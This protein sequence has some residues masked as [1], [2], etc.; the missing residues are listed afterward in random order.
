MGKFRS[1]LASGLLASISLCAL[2]EQPIS[3]GSY[4]AC[5]LADGEWVQMPNSS[6]QRHCLAKWTRSR[7]DAAG[8]GWISTSERCALPWSKE[9]MIR[10]CAAAGGEWGTHG[11]RLPHCYFAFE[12][13]ACLAEGGAW[14]RVGFAQLG[15]CGRAGR[16]SGKPCADSHECQ[17]GCVA[18]EKP[19][20]R[21]MPVQGKC[22]ANDNP[23]EC[24]A[25]V[26]KGLT[27]R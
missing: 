16:D 12:E 20:T 7:C 17:H 2:A 10:Q 21:E 11:A 24:G 23:F 22:A 1:A 19:A 3:I 5:T 4:D 6:W 27:F 9:D 25:R 13:R 18:T 26:E 8:G 14:E 15:R